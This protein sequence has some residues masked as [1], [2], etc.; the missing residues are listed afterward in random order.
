MY[1]TKAFKSGGILK[2]GSVFQL[3]TQDP[4]VSASDG[5]LNFGGGIP[6]PGF[7]GS[8]GKLFS[9]SLK[10]RTTDTGTINWSSGAVLA[11]DGKGTNIL[12]SMGGG[13]YAL[14]PKIITPS[15]PPSGPTVPAP[16]PTTA[17]GVPAAPEITSSTH[18]DPNLWYANSN[19]SFEWQLPSGVTG[20]SFMLTESP[21]SNPGPISD[22]LITSKKFENKKDAIHY[23]HIRFRNRRGWGEIT[24]RRVLIDTI[25]PEP[26]KVALYDGGDATNP[27]P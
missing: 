9:I 17:T 8:A 18:P 19:P 21:T 2:S 22:G 26:F 4:V 6:N 5:T 14:N 10:V 12:V 27:A 7:T 11:N 20:V 24:H 3:W 25:S 13:S 1:H 23:F 16:A 15:A